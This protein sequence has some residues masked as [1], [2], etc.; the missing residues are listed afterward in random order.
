MP[1]AA[2]M[3]V[4]QNVL[5]EPRQTRAELNALGSRLTQ[6]QAGELELG[7]DAMHGLLRQPERGNDLGWGAAARLF[8]DVVEKAEC[9]QSRGVWLVAFRCS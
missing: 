7:D 2:G 1:L 6:E 4:H 8:V 3:A 5:G 9:A